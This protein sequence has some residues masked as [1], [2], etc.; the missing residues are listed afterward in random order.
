MKWNSHLKVLAMSE[1]EQFKWLCDKGITDGS[2]ARSQITHKIV[3]RWIRIE[4]ADLAF[5]LRDEVCKDSL[6]CDNYRKALHLVYQSFCKSQRGT[7]RQ[8]LIP[9][10]L[11]LESFIVAIER[12][13]AALIAKESQVKNE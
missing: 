9:Y 5:R 13:I 4:F 8:N 12:I 11:W 10:E 3:T 2:L 1:E 7:I 6:G